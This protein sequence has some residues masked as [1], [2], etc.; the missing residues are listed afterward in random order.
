MKRK[1][2]TFALVS[3]V[4]IEV[5]MCFYAKLKIPVQLIPF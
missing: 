1:R 3:Y 2:N 4:D 5:S